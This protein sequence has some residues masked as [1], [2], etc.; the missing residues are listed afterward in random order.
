MPVGRSAALRLRFLNGAERGRVV[1]WRG[2]ECRIGRSRD[3]DL[4]LP[5]R[6]DAQAGAHHA[7]ARRDRGQWWIHDL[8]SMNGTFVNGVRVTRAPLHPG[9]RLVFGDVECAVIRGSAVPVKTI[10]VASAAAAL[11]IAYALGG[12]AR[13]PFEKPAA[14]VAESTYLIAFEGT[15]GRQAI[16]TAFVVQPTLLATNAHVADTLR[17]FMTAN[18]DS[19]GVALRSDSD[20]RVQIVETLVHPRWRRGSLEDDAALLRLERTAQGAPLTLA[21]RDTVTALRRGVPLATFGFPTAATDVAHPRGRLTL[22][23]MG[24]L[25]D[26]RYLATGLAIAPGMSGSPIFLASG[27]VVGLVAGG[28][29]VVAPDQST[30]PSGTGLNWGVSSAAVQDLLRGESATRH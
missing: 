23:V 11:A 7:V 8:D 10:A 5:D 15:A 24:D 20:E 21:D 17:A 9:D 16:G 27:V 1:V 26:G 19:P 6:Q 2:S 29:F 14:V 12:A 3:N 30:R 22:D 18:P 28:D 25:R 13:A 4:T